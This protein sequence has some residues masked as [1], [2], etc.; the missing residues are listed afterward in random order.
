MYS[1][2]NK[3]IFLI[4][5]SAFFLLTTPLTVYAAD[6]FGSLFVYYGGTVK[7]TPGTARPADQFMSKRSFRCGYKEYVTEVTVKG[8]GPSANRVWVKVYG[9][10]GTQGASLVE[11]TKDQ[12]NKS[13]TCPTVKMKQTEQWY[14]V[15]LEYS[16][17]NF[18]AK[19]RNYVK[20][21]LF[22]IE[23]IKTNKGEYILNPPSL[24][25]DSVKP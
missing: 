7:T 10:N 22:W 19:N 9:L 3:S 14:A 24:E 21:S 20:P 11:V 15:S 8:Y 6:E 2:I 25:R 1:A 4:I 17:E 16:K 23:K 12:A 5:L 18:M 13:M